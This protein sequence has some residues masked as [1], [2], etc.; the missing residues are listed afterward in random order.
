MVMLTFGKIVCMLLA[1]SYL[2]KYLFV[3]MLYIHAG[4]L[5]LIMI[6]VTVFGLTVMIR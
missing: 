4:T 2:N 5:Q 3:P 1:I 6:I